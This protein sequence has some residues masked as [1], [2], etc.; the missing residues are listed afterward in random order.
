MVDI[1]RKS[2]VEVGSKFATKWRWW[3]SVARQVWTQLRAVVSEAGCGNGEVNP[4][5]VHDQL[6]LLS[7][8]SCLLLVHDDWL[9]LS[10][11]LR[12][13]DFSLLDHCSFLLCLAL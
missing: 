6:T 9:S 4:D 7:I 2:K 5:N 10:L 3:W 12:S 13:F 1:D 11:D 8:H